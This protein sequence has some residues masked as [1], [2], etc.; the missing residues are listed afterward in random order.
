LQTNAIEQEATIERIE[1]CVTWYGSSAADSFDLLSGL[2]ISEWDD[3][4]PGFST[5]DPG[6]ISDAMRPNWLRL[7]YD[8]CAMAQVGGL[9]ITTVQRVVQRVDL[10]RPISIRTGKALFLAINQ[11]STGGNTVGCSVIMRLWLNRT[12]A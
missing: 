9:S 7:N 12:V 8:T 5:Q 11:Q 6:S 10:K 2:Y 3:S 4:L 1:G